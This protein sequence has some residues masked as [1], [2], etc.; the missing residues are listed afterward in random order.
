LIIVCAYL[1]LPLDSFA[2]LNPAFSGSLHNRTSLTLEI[3]P[4]EEPASHSPCSDR[5]GSDG[6]KPTCSCCS[7]CSF[8]APLASGIVF[9]PTATEHFQPE[10]FQRLPQVYLAIFVPPQNRA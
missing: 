3:A 6:C 2:T 9:R 8:F 5:H 4:S 7:C 1:F 10:Q